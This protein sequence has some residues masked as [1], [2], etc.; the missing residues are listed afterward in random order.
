MKRL[1]L[2]TVFLISIQYLYAQPAKK[3]TPQKKPTS[4][5][6]INKLLDEAMKEEG[7]SKEEQEEMKKLMKVVMP[8]LNEVNSKTADYPEFTKNSL[9]IPKK[10][11]AGISAMNKKS[12]SK[13]EIA[14]YAT[15][16]Y[17]K[18]LAKGDASEMAIVKKVI[19]Q[20][21]KAADISSAAILAMLQG[22]PQAA[23]A[24][25]I[26]AVS[27][28]PANLTWQNNMSSLLTSYGFPELAMPVLR[29]LNNELPV[30]ST[31]LNNL[32]HAWLG[33]GETDSAKR[34]LSFAS[35][36]NPLHPEAK[37]CGGLI[38]ELKG[39][40][41]KAGKIYEEA[42]E[43]SPNPFT[44]QVMKNH[45]KK[46]NLQNLDFEKIKKMI[47]IYEYFPPNWM[48]EI[49]VM[50]NNVQNY[51]E[52]N[53]IKSSYAEMI[54]EFKTKVE[55]MT[56]KLSLELDDLHN[57]G[58]DVFVK[59]M[60]TETMKGLSF[61]SKPA[62]IVLGVLSSY[63]T[64]FQLDHAE[65]LKKM[66]QWKANLQIEKQKKI[67]VI[68]KKI[69]DSKGTRCETFKQ[70][71]DN[72]EN[73]FMVTV[74]TRLRNY[75]MKTT[76]EIRQ[77][78]NAWCTWNWYVSGNTKNYILIQDVGFT[79][80]LADLYGGI[81]D[82]MEI[83]PE[84][85]NPK[86]Y[87][88]KKQFTAPEIPNFTCP[89]VVSI[90]AGPEWQKLVAAA[91][92]FDANSYGIKKTDKPV[93]NVTVATGSGKSV[94][95][96]GM[97][98]SYKT[99]NGGITPG[100]ADVEA[101][102]DKGL[103]NAFR[104]VNGKPTDQQVGDAIDKGLSDAMKR[105]QE[106]RKQGIIG[107]DDELVPLP[108][109]PDENDPVPLPKLPK[110]ELT[111]LDRKLLTKYKLY[112]ELMDK[113]LTA[114]CSNVKSAKDN[115]KEQLDRMM[116][117]VKELEAFENMMEEIKRLE[118]EISQKEELRKKIEEFKKAADELDQ[119]SEMKEFL[120]RAEQLNKEMEA[121]DEK[122]VFKQKMEK[123][124]SLV[125]EME[126]IPVLVKEIQT[127]GLQ[128]SISSGLQAPGT[129]NLPKSLFQ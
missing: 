6:D 98:P 116:K 102:I 83:L 107:D 70:E 96:P 125:E 30:N 11:I 35:R 15:G 94:A 1:L 109:L 92:D 124:I 104:K 18:I 105:V 122:K 100:G 78:L 22:H 56:N 63:Q 77:W 34:Y 95:Q 57:K 97:N 112:K 29:K 72:L 123:I 26:K 121:M 8:A 76:E 49:P 84:H 41:I 118:N 89:A 71:L 127:N 14:G 108:K 61:M 55:E 82:G 43:L 69:S 20:T 74:N 68:Y 38:E 67:D 10:D 24:L 93:P 45:N 129:F 73:Q 62:T 80:Y 16:L 50:S 103:M 7:M 75:L 111:P 31:V 19:L 66:I 48:P 86:T 2:T 119:F 9:L 27:T 17:N 64:K 12:L 32:G 51:N 42:M 4:Q 91:K 33:L 47:A 3:P 28:E 5:Q 65:E 37:L 120:S 88:V 46:S 52:D 44:D 39:D 113:M 110:D 58:E 126:A 106:R 114:D 40:P 85:C 87:D 25:S 36:A 90:P 54:S 79:G 99:A 21:P 23:L 128:S 117:K 60:M 101:A 81:V 53:A 115:L 13:S 59:E